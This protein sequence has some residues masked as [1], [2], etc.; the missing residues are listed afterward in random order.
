MLEADISECCHALY[1]D[2]KDYFSK[3]TFTGRRVGFSA[4]LGYGDSYHYPLS[5]QDENG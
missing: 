4:S 3:R 5:I 2:P 1:H